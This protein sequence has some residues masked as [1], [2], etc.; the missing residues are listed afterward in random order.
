MVYKTDV[1]VRFVPEIV[2]ARLDINKEA[3]PNV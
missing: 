2:G 3:A 1:R